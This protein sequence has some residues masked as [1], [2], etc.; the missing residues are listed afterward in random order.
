M[1]ASLILLGLAYEYTTRMHTH[2]Y[3][4][5]WQNT[6]CIFAIGALVVLMF[7]PRVESFLRNNIAT[8]AYL[9]KAFVNDAYSYHYASSFGENVSED[10]LRQIHK[11][12]ELAGGALR[13]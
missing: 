3:V 5:I 7:A 12:V 8:Q 6:Y 9:Q 10:M 1:I 13:S 11:G 4:P 2:R